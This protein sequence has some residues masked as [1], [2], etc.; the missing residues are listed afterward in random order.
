MS[1]ALL[2]A[3]ASG[4][5]VVATR[6]GAAADVIKDGVTGII[7]PPERPEELA[8]ALIFLLGDASSRREISA[9]ARQSAVTDFH[10]GATVDRYLRL[11]EDLVTS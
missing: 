8:N 6:V 5:P 9:R 11:Y 7:V 4:L 2:E 1:N 3:L 10:I